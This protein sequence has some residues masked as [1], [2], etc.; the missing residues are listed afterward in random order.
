MIPTG[1][2]KS[3]AINQARV[4]SR[5]KRDFLKDI[6]QQL[7][8]KPLL[9]CGQNIS[10]LDYD[11]IWRTSLSSESPAVLLNKWQRF[12]VFAHSRNRLRVDMV[13][14]NEFQFQ[15]YTVEG[16]V[17]STPENLLIC[18]LVIGLLEAIGCVGLYCDIAMKDGKA[19]RIRENGMFCLPENPR[20][21]TAVSWKIGWDSQTNVRARNTNN[22]PASELQLPKLKLPSFTKSRNREL[23]KSLL[24]HLVRD[25]SRQWQVCELAQTMGMSSRTL[26]RKL[27]DIDI[28]F[29]NLVRLVRIHEACRLLKD[30]KSSLTVIGFCSGFSDSAHF[31]RD[32]RASVGLT[33]TQ[34]RAFI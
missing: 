20:E 13:S 11:P 34:Y 28:S 32:F 5:T 6:W 7:G 2:G 30:T 3:A 24:N 10:K 19:I 9:S 29:T 1:L 18:G 25:V 14:K 27:A 17:P 16:S 26:Q 22:S 8:A 15:R 23:V 4:A 31:S 12:E 33:P 21:I